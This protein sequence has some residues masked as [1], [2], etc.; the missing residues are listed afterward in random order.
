MTIP[1]SAGVAP[2]DDDDAY[3]RFRDAMATDLLIGRVPPGQDGIIRHALANAGLGAAQARAFVHRLLA[4]L[5]RGVDLH[6]V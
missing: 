3:R 4:D 1:D 6:R 2:G 5:Q